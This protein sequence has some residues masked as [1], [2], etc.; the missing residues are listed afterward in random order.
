MLPAHLVL[1]TLFRNR[2]S[3]FGFNAPA[4]IGIGA[5]LPPTPENRR[6]SLPGA[7]THRLSLPQICNRRPTSVQCAHRGPL[8]KTDTGVMNGLGFAGGWLEMG[9]SG[10]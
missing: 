2:N 7:R 9:S 6:A 10:A 5:N 8:S 4:R 3:S 1:Y